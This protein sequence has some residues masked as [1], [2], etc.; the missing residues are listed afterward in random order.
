MKIFILLT[1]VALALSKED[2]LKA[3][4][5]SPALT[6]NLYNNYKTQQHLRF[7]PQEDRM[8]FRLFRKSAAIVADENSVEEETARFTVNFFSSLTAAEKRSYLGLNATGL[9]ANPAPVL[10]AGAPRRSVPTQKLWVNEGKVTD[11]K[12]QGSCGSCWTFSAVGGLE[13]RY[14]EVTGRLRN[15]A[16][17]E[18]LDCER[19]SYGC[20]GGWPKYCYDYSQ[21]NGGRLAATADYKYESRYTGCKGYSTPDAMVGAKIVGYTAVPATEDS[22]IEALSEGALSVCFEVTDKTSYYSSGIL[23]DDTCRSYANHAVT[24]VG[25]TPSYVL[26]KNSWGKWWGDNGYIKFA[27]GH[28]NCQLWNFSVFPLLKTTGV[29]D[30]GP[31]DKVSDYRTDGSVVPTDSPTDAPTD[32]PNCFDAYPP[33]Y[34]HW[35]DTDY[36]RNDYCRKTCGVCGGGQDKCP[37]GTVRC[38]D[39][40]CRHEH[41][42]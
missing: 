4:L 24:A 6:L 15:F 33:C 7:A 10:T 22:N 21:Q 14:K 41:M 8:R 36:I 37:S 17:Q 29:A 1:V 35:C 34:D 27:R 2:P 13:S 32:D 19:K 9:Q 18:Y 23:R 5:R 26:V 31:D 12:N 40:V 16:E 42:C 28:H 3:I 30:T 25:Y 11:I 38:A 39:G 20:S